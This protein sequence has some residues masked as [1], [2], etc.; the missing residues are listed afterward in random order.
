MKKI[1]IFTILGILL[2]GSITFVM[3]KNLDKQKI[4]KI[5]LEDKTYEYYV[6]RLDKVTSDKEIAKNKEIL[7]QELINMQKDLDY[8]IKNRNKLIEDCKKQYPLN[9]IDDK[10]E[11]YIYN[12]NMQGMCEIDIDLKISD[13]NYSITQYIP[14]QLNNYDKYK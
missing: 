11:E 14:D 12:L 4:E 5:K 8:L 13:L 1:M 10:N 3:T 7:N 6:Y 9:N 2:I